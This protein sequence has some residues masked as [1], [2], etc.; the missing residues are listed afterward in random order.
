MTRSILQTRIRRRNDATQNQYRDSATQGNNSAV[1]CHVRF[2]AALDKS[3]EKRD[4]TSA[5]NLRDNYDANAMPRKISFV[6]VHATG[7]LRVVWG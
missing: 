2:S 4:G 3:T 5:A 6:V 1:R 7:E